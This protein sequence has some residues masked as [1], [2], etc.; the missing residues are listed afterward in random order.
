MRRVGVLGFSVEGNKSSLVGRW[1]RTDLDVSEH[2][3][4]HWGE[5]YGAKDICM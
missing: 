1:L 3:I 4:L 2:V 5:G